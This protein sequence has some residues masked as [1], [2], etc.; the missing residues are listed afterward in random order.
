MWE[1][2]EDSSSCQRLKI[3]KKSRALVSSWVDGEMP[4]IQEMKI[5]GVFSLQPICLENNKF[6]ECPMGGDKKLDMS[7]STLDIVPQVHTPKLYLG[8]SPSPQDL[9]T[10]GQSNS[11]IQTTKEFFDCEKEK[12]HPN[13]LVVY[14]LWHCQICTKNTGI[15]D[16]DIAIYWHRTWVLKCD[17][18]L[19]EQRTLKYWIMT[20]QS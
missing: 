7:P 17:I 5:Q 2:G 15:L 18:T 11:I 1:L 12:N 3:T 19:S 10:P 4:I 8:L 6:D 14:R 16:C 9:S 13:Q 20:M